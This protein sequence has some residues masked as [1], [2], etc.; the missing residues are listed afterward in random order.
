MRYLTWIEKDD[1]S[2]ATHFGQINFHF[3]RFRNE[4]SQDTIEDG[5]NAMV[6]QSA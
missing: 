1:G 3:L 4:L 6:G 2:Q 5:S